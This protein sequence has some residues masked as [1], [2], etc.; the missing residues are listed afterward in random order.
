MGNIWTGNFG[1]VLDWGVESGTVD[2]LDTTGR[3]D[4]IALFG[5]EKNCLL[6]MDVDADF[7]IFTGDVLI[8]FSPKETESFW[9]GFSGKLDVVLS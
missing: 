3:D 9:M 4:G 6:S 2:G 7:S 8:S 5:S 1:T